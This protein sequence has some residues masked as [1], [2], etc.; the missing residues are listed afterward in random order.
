MSP[1]RLHDIFANQE[2]PVAVSAP[3]AS[4][5]MACPLTLQ[6]APRP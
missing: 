2:P 5:F 3:M 4:G 6:A 1:H